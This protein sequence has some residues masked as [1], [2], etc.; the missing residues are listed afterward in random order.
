METL[1]DDL[2]ISFQHKEHP[3]EQQNTVDK[4]TC[5]LY[6]CW[7]QSLHAFGL[8][9]LLQLFSLNHQQFLDRLLSLKV[10][11]RVRLWL[12]AHLA[13]C[14]P[15]TV[16]PNRHPMTRLRVIDVLVG[17]NRAVQLVSPVCLLNQLQGWFIT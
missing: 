17:K 1:P 7:C 16:A 13:R 5:Q 4:C 15:P 8:F 6:P 12:S 11:L 14:K 10:S 3:Q 9:Q 2:V